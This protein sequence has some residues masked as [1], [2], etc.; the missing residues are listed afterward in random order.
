MTLTNGFEV[1][2]DEKA[3]DDWEVMEIVCELDA[4][5]FSRLPD[6]FVTLLGKEQ[7]QALKK[8]LKEHSESGRCTTTDMS[9]ALGEIFAGLKEGK[10]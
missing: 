8:H 4:E 3:L 9:A 10:K 1:T 2:V 6:L 5:H 7:Y